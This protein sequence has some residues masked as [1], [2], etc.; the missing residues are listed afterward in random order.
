MLYCGWAREILHHRPDRI[1]ETLEIPSGKH[2]KHDGK[3]PFF[4]GKST[5]SMAIFNSHVSLPEGNGISHQLV[6]D[7][8]GPSTVCL[9][10]VA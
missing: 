1:V 8:A 4:M 2:T 7:F 6:Q 9:R 3:S 5:I 10:K